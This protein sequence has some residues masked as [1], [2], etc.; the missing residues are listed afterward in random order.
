MIC[1]LIVGEVAVEEAI[2]S[3]IGCYP[4]SVP[5]VYEH[6]LDQIEA[7]SQRCHLF[8]VI[9]IDGMLVGDEHRAIICVTHNESIARSPSVIGCQQVQT[10]ILHT[11]DAILSKG[12]ER[13]ALAMVAIDVTLGNEN[14]HDRVHIKMTVRCHHVEDTIIVNRFKAVACHF[15]QSALLLLLV[16]QQHI[17]IWKVG[18][19]E[20]VQQPL[21]LW[22][23]RT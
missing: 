18:S 7:P 13:I 16:F 14:S 17:A 22:I 3:L 8:S 12:I 2:Q 6:V 19:V 21:P 10:V 9:A 4:Q 23:K 15:A 11:I 20:V 1:E 5:A